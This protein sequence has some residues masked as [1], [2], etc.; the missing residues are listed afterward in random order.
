MTASFAGFPKEL[1]T[2]LEALSKNNNR[3]W[4]NAN[5]QR[6][7]TDV[8]APVMSFITEVGHFL[9]TLSTAMVADTRRTGGSMFRIYRDTRFSKDKRPYKENVGC[10][11]RHIDGKNA[12]TPGFYVHLSPREVF[13]GGGIWRPDTPTLNRIRDAIVEHP[14]EWQTVLDNHDFSRYFG[15]LASG[16]KLKR[17]PRGYEADHPYAADLKRKDFTAIKTLDPASALSPEFMKEVKTAFT[18]VSPLLAFVARH[19]GYPY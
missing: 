18:A 2:F 13:I 11:F 15:A 16:D 19:T 4:F 5:R 7:E 14:S 3:E 1:F 8:V 10:Q 9:P 17:I 6:Y 12:H